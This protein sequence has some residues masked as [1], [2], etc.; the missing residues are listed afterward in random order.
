MGQDMCSVF[1]KD[2][3]KNGG[4]DWETIFFITAPSIGTKF[5]YS[6]A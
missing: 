3:A 4:G 2:G 1:L 5:H 6:Q